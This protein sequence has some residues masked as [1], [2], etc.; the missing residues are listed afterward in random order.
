M[1]AFEA[2]E[3]RNIK[4]SESD[5]KQP[6]LVRAVAA[7]KTY[8]KINPL[9]KAVQLHHEAELYAQRIPDACRALNIAALSAAIKHGVKSR[10]K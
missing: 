5:R 7:E 9:V 1:D 8:R 4:K 6:R 2:H 10:E 3:P